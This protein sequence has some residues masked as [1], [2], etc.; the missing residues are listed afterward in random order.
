[1]S[2]GREPNSHPRVTSKSVVYGLAGVWAVLVMISLVVS[3]GGESD[4]RG[5]AAGL[6]RMATFM[7]WQ[8]RALVVA[9]AAALFTRVASG[10]GA[11]RIKLAGYLPLA[12]SVF[13][14]GVLVAMIAFRVL[15][16]PA[17]A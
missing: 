4:G 12:M 8:V 2:H 15:V 17:F 1:M 3:L 14:V 9:I 10:R 5:S 16:R 13:M 6:A 7:T 11:E